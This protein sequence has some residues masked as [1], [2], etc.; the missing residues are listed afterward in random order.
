[1]LPDD[2]RIFI[3]VAYVNS[4]YA[5]RI[6]DHDHPAEVAVEEAFADGVGVLVGVGVAVVGAVVTGPPADG[7]FDSAAT[8]GSKEDAK[9]E[10]G[11]VGCVCPEAVITWPPSVFIVWESDLWLLP[12]V[13]PRPVAK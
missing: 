13:I 5:S 1:M 8:N 6:L 12:A 2:D 4:P 10:G 11:G 9:R 7:S 3:E